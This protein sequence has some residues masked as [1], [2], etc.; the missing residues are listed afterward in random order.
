MHF[1]DVINAQRFT[2]HK[3]VCH[4]LTVISLLPGSSLMNV[5]TSSYT[6]LLLIPSGYFPFQAIFKILYLPAGPLFRYSCSMKSKKRSNSGRFPDI[7]CAAAFIFTFGT[8][9]YQF[10]V[11]FQPCRP[12]LAIVSDSCGVFSWFPALWS[13]EK[14]RLLL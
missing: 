14:V 4:I 6:V 9:R 10:Q 2:E 3:G 12:D 7:S 13:Q 1:K 5:I 8:C 11:P